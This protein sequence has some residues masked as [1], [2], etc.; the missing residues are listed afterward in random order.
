MISEEVDGDL[1]ERAVELARTLKP[2]AQPDPRVPPVPPE[3]DLMGLS[4]K[5]DEILRHAIVEGAK[6]PIDR[7]LELEAKCFGEVY[8]T[9]DHRIGLDNY[10]KTS[11]KQPAKFVHA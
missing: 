4:R 9:R 3:V 6:L 7:A 1:I 5:V 11:L 2:A 8:A 10:L